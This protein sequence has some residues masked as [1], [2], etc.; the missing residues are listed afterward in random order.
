MWSLIRLAIRLSHHGP[1]CGP[2]ASASLSVLVIL[3]ALAQ[4]TFGILSLY[5]VRVW[6]FFALNAAYICNGVAVLLLEKALPLT[7]KSTYLCDTTAGTT[8]SQESADV[9]LPAVYFFF[10]YIYQVVQI[11]KGKPA[12]PLTHIDHPEHNPWIYALFSVCVFT[13]AIVCT[14]V[15]VYM[16]LASIEGGVIGAAT[17]GVIASCVSYITYIHVIPQFHCPHIQ[18]A[19]H[20][21]R[22]SKTK[23]HA[24]SI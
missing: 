8:I 4:F 18:R 12:Q 21:L 2:D 5:P 10:Y 6:F 16:Q 15:Q 7:N 3:P 13:F 24:P 11:Y 17:G 9:W 23:L 22:L 20:I 14:W 1:T 19:L